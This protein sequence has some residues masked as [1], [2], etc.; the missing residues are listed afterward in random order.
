MRNLLIALALVLVVG[1]SASAGNRDSVNNGAEKSNRAFT[2]Y[3]GSPI[4]E[5]CDSKEIGKIRLCEFF[6]IGVV[7]GFEQ[8]KDNSAAPYCLPLSNTHLQI[9]RVVIKYLRDNPGKL[10]LSSGFL[11]LEALKETFPCKK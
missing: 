7:T 2:W 1:G 9:T 8:V 6:I 3:K 11:I 5:I 10:H 4:V